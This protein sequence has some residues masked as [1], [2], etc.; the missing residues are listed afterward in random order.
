MWLPAWLGRT[1]VTLYMEFKN[2]LFT[3]Q[4]AQE[5]L[6]AKENWLAVVFSK[7]HS[8]KIL[9]I[10]ERSKPRLYRLLDP[11]NFFL[12]AGETIKNL[13]KIPQDRYIKVICDSFRHISSMFRLTSFAVY[14]SVARGKAKKNS[15]VDVLLIS[16]DFSGSLGSR[17]E[18]LC[19]IETLIEEELTW[20]R[21]HGVYVRLSFYPLRANEAR[22]KPFLFLDLTE[23]AVILYDENCFLE[24]ILVELKSKLK[25]QGAKKVFVNEENWYWDLKPQY[26]FGEVIEIT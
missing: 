13:D 14:G 18:K 1:Y 26:R 20:L 12:L 6:S 19:L 8:K 11:L 10:F 7:L 23:E 24:K 2:E 9:M 22:R 17:I 16:N 25:E 4:E 3:F 21:K 5:L 15:D